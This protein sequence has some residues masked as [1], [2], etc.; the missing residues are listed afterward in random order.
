MASG[1][2]VIHPVSAAYMDTKMEAIDD[3]IE[4]FATKERARTDD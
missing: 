3:K 1:V 2:P 4:L